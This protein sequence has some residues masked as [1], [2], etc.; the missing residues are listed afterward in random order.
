MITHQDRQ[1]GWWSRRRD[2]GDACAGMTE[3]ETQRLSFARRIGVPQNACKIAEYCPRRWQEMP[4]L[5]MRERGPGAHN[6]ANF[7]RPMLVRNGPQRLGRIS[8]RHFKFQRTHGPEFG[9]PRPKC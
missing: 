1:N 7:L 2:F 8:T 3:L 6:G 9:R 4:R 5:A